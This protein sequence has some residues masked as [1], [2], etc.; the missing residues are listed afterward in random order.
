MHG[1]NEHSGRYD[2]LA[3]RLNEIG[4]KVYGM[5]WTGE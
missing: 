1:L 4:I 2:H 5:D 3:R